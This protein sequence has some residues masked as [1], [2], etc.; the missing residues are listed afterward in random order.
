MGCYNQT[1]Q[2]KTHVKT[3]IEN[4]AEHAR[5]TT[6]VNNVEH[7]REAT[8]C[9]ESQQRIKYQV[10]RILIPARRVLCIE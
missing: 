4:N 2:I 8:L 6:I 5:E 1:Q 9:V 10:W 7:A 3:Q